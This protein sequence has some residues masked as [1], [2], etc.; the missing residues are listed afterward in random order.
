[1]EGNLEV[2]SGAMGLADAAAEFNRRT[3]A[4]QTHDKKTYEKKTVGFLKQMTKDM[5]GSS[6]V[7]APL[8]RKKCGE[9]IIEGNKRC[10]WGCKEN[11]INPKTGRGRKMNLKEKKKELDAMKEAGL[12]NQYQYDKLNKEGNV[13][14]YKERCHK[15]RGVADADSR[16]FDTALQA[17]PLS[18]EELTLEERGGLQKKSKRRVAKGRKKSKRRVTKGRKKSKRRKSHTRHR[19]KRTKRR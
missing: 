13:M 14:F 18:P 5:A 15:E 2:P 7:C 9:A 10:K 12:I 17:T 6:D 16:Q 19:T 8:N 3:G 1:M 4:Q 11:E